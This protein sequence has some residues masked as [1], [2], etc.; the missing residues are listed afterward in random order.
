MSHATA[1]QNGWN[2]FHVVTHKRHDSISPPKHDSWHVLLVLPSQYTVRFQCLHCAKLSTHNYS[3]VAPC[4]DLCMPFYRRQW[5]LPCHSLVWQYCQGMGS[6]W[7]DPFEDFSWSWREGDVCGY[8]PRYV[9]GIC[10]ASCS[11]VIHMWLTTSLLWF[12]APLHPWYSAQLKNNSYY[13]LFTLKVK[14]H[15]NLL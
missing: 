1:R 11:N 2:W 10:S 8:L 15:Y 14:P 9:S 12:G 3:S 13:K 6:S 4:W 5:A 7:V